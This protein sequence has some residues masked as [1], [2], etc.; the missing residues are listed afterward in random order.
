MNGRI[1]KPIFP[2]VFGSW[3][4]ISLLFLAG[5]LTAYAVEY[6]YQAIQDWTGD[7]VIN[8]YDRLYYNVILF[9]PAAGYGEWPAT[10]NGDFIYDPHAP[11]VITNNGT[12][13][14]GICH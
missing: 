13:Y 14:C 11:V 6:N 8:T 1:A 12:G 9:N 5:V 7:G 4:R 3:I 2:R 10:P